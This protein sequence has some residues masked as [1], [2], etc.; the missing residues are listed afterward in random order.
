MTHI[1][2][3]IYI[4]LLLFFLALLNVSAYAQAPYW[5]W[6][7]NNATGFTD[8]CSLAVDPSGN[9]YVAGTFLDGTI[10]FGTTNLVNAGTYFSDIY[11][12]KY[13]TSGNVLWATRAGGAASEKATA[14]AVDAN[15]NSYVTGGFAGIHPMDFGTISLTNLNPFGQY[16]VFIAKYD[17][18]GSLVWAKSAGSTSVDLSRGIAVDGNGNI[19]FT[20][21]FYGPTMSFGS[22]A[23][24]NS[25]PNGIGT[26]YFTAKYDASGNAVWAVKN[27]GS[28]HAEGIGVAVDGAGNS[29]VTGYF[30]DPTIT[31]DTITL[32]KT[33]SSEMF[34][35]K[36]D[37]SG[38]AV[39]AKNSPSTNGVS[40]RSVSV[41]VTG[42]I[43]VTGNFL[44]AVSFGTTTL[45][46]SSGQWDVFLTKYDA[47]GNVIWAR[48]AGG[49]NNDY[50]SEVVVDGGG[51][52][53][54]TGR[55]SSA[56]MSFGASN[57][58]NTKGGSGSD[59]FV[60]K[61][62][63]SGNVLWAINTGGTG[64]KNDEGTG[65]GV[66]ANGNSYVAGIF[67]SASVP[68]GTT[69]LN[70]TAGPTGKN[71]FVAKLPLCISQPSQPG[72]ITGN[73][74]PCEG[75]N[76]LYSVAAVAGAT[77]YIWTLPSGWT[78]TSNASSI[79][80]KVGASAGTITV[81]AYNGCGPGSVQS[82]TVTPVLLPAPP[83]TGTGN[84]TPCSGSVETYSVAPVAGAT[85]YIWTMP[86][87]WTG[88]STTN[89]ISVTVGTN[90]G[91]WTVAAVNGCGAGPVKTYSTS[92][93]IPSP[94][95]T[96]TQS[97]NTFSAT[98]SFLSYQWYV[99]GNPI[100][101]AINQTY[102]TTLSGNYYVVVTDGSFCL[103]KSNTIGIGLGIEEVLN[104]KGIFIAPNP[105]NDV[106]FIT[107]K[108]GIGSVSVF[109]ALG[110]KVLE[111]TIEGKNGQVSVKHLPTGLYL[112]KSGASNLKILKE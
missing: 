29:Y 55:F 40:G 72:S 47:A 8:E 21:S 42:N 32:T 33:G 2:S 4:P 101:G 25:N 91:S 112:L 48:S 75:S 83:G 71:M 38:N 87:G 22:I 14:I 90:S 41:D 9:S 10:S 81:A 74:T 80:A 65:I 104:D 86:P 37:P 3:A 13:D 77:S 59:V 19:Y 64:N 12:V 69:T 79:L 23:L 70:N 11:V 7:K 46:T 63:P 16:D 108:M 39:W 97:G 61:Y 105:V 95:V 36:Y 107:G 58:I 62:D 15:G 103:G 92:Y 102:T 20:G 76:Q 17:A 110:R 34:I 78:G 89:T 82:F 111:E 67:N 1:R 53:Y 24:N 109:D 45:A 73:A 27:V 6:A 98:G 84:P 106:L 35:V 54:I 93:V 43:Y 66:D 31:F 51:H 28:T 88:S 68:F 60:A 49:G 100:P 30:S 56:S 85:S 99:N 94:S 5:V 18:N 44:G 52:A 57:L 26:N 50:S 96:I